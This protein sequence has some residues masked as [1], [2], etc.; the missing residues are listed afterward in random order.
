MKSMKLW[1][2]QPATRWFEALPIGNGRI[3]GMVYGG[4]N[5]EVIDLTETTCYSGEDFPGNCPA[6]SPDAYRRAREAL[7]A[8]DYE[9]GEQALQGMLGDMTNYGTNLPLGHLR[10]RMR[11]PGTESGDYRR[12]L[13]LDSAL[14]RV[15]YRCGETVCTRTAFAS[16]PDQVLV[17]R[18]VGDRPGSVSLSVTID[19]DANPFRVTAAD[20]DLLL[21]GSARETTHSDGQTGVDIH[22]RIRVLSEGGDRETDNTSIHLSDADEILILVGLGTTFGGHDPVAG[23]RDQVHRAAARTYD[24]LRDRHVADH[25]VLFRRTTLSLGERAETGVPTDERLRAVRDG[26]TDLGLVGLMFQFGRYSLI[27]SSRAD[28][29]LPAHLQ[30]VWNDNEACRIGWTCDMHLDINTQMNYW[31]AEGTQLTECIPPLVDWL[32]KIIV[33]SG[34]RTARATYEL[35][36]WVAHT[37]A[38][39][40]G[41]TAPGRASYWGLHPTGGV[42]I[43]THLWEHFLYGRDIGF[44]RDHA[45]PMLREAAEF[46]LAYLVEDPKTGYLLS[47]PS[48]SPENNFRWK[49][50]TYTNS[51]GAV[52]DSVLLRTLFGICVEA[53]EI[54]DTDR[55]FAARCAEAAAR[56]PPLAIGARGQLMEWLEDLEEATPNHRHTCH[57]VAVFPYHEID[58]VR[59]PELA[60]AV[61]RTIALRM[62]ADEPWEDTGW[63]RSNLILYAARLRDA[64]VAGQH[65]QAKLQGLTEDNLMVYAPPHG[66][67]LKNVYEMDGNT[68]LTSGIVEMLIQSHDGTLHLLPALPPA[69]RE[70]QVRGLRARGGFLIDLEWKH[71]RLE[72]VA[73]KAAEAGAACTIRYQGQS[74]EIDLHKTVVLD[75]SLSPTEKQE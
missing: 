35:P 62:N 6:G 53:S 38:N 59:T 26:G 37:I 55:E 13:D 50:K 5:E 18:I 36:G 31:P 16:N 58:P 34:R 17:M 66:G 61:R 30:G 1:Y 15:T 9:A 57:L 67:A 20:G 29:P 39:P 69:W 2:R 10:V 4:T 42:W 68:G 28:S 27:A 22:G 33:P 49:E 8:R 64:E 74:M 14:S 60:D 65:V 12:E 23:C 45:Y 43:A 41:F 40:W 44:L 73:V 52:C 32:E 21:D 25:Q 48:H 19:G 3:G 63:S 51:M 24:D 56:L 47:G 11:H 71:G 7:L 70:G 75:G 46:F 54:L 72:R